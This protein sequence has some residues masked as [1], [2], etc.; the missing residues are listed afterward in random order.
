MCRDSLNIFF[1]RKEKLNAFPRAVFPRS[2]NSVEK[3]IYR[4][5]ELNDLPVFRKT[6]TFFISCRSFTKFKRQS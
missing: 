5:F 4:D 3:S 2:R 1:T 6:I